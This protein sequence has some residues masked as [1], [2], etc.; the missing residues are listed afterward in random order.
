MRWTRPRGVAGSSPTPHSPQGRASVSASPVVF[1]HGAHS[2]RREPSSSSRSASSSVNRDA[3]GSQTGPGS[4]Q[5]SPLLLLPQVPP[6]GALTGLYCVPSS[7]SV[8]HAAG[9]LLE[10]P[11]PGLRVRPRAL[12]AGC[13]SPLAEAG[14]AASPNPQSPRGCGRSP[15]TQDAAFSRQQARGFLRVSV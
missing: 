11:H 5:F 15:R 9:H 3:S 8:P 6:L 10:P 12:R 14:D 13:W 4:S 7:V 1:T 2:P